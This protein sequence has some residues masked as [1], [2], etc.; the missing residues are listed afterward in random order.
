MPKCDL[1]TKELKVIK[2]LDNGAP[3]YCKECCRYRAE[4]RARKHKRA[5]ARRLE[6]VREKRL[7]ASEAFEQHLNRASSVVSTWPKWKQELLGGTAS[8]ETRDDG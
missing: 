3:R 6:R 1:C 4:C 5:N 2:G 7:V 8:K